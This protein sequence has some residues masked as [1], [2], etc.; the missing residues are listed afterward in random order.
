MPVLTQHD[1]RIK[2]AHY[3]LDLSAEMAREGAK[4]DKAAE[5]DL[6]ISRAIEEGMAP[7]SAIGWPCPR[8][9]SN[10]LNQPD[11]GAAN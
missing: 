3:Y 2:F 8:A 5:W 10:I 11:F 4:V 7:C 1:I 6:F 9:L